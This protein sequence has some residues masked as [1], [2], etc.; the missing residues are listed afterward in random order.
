[1]QKAVTD[2]NGLM[3]DGTGTIQTGNVLMDNKT[4]AVYGFI[5]GLDFSQSQVN[6]AFDTKRS[7]GSSIK[8]ILAMSSHRYGTNGLCKC[9]IKLSSQI[10]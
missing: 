7:P 10:L 4:G 5:G 9:L 8:P 6:H 2:Y 3:Q 1:M